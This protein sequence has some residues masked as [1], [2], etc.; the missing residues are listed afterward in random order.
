MRKPILMQ[1][2][3]LSPVSRF[4]PANS[5]VPANSMA[6]PKWIKDKLFNLKMDFSAKDTVWEEKN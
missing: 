4:L 5:M 6:F 1:M 2:R 3:L